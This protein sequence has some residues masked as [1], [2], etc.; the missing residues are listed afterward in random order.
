VVDLV[1]LSNPLVISESRRI[2]AP[3]TAIFAVLKDPTRHHQFDGST[4]VRDSDAPPIEAVGD[5]FIMRM[6]NDE[7]GDYEMRSEVIA[8]VP[9]HEIA[10]APQRHDVVEESWNHRWGWRLT[11]DGDATD[12][13]A[14]FDCTRV[15]A[16]GQRILRGGEWSR[17]I[18]RRSLENLENLFVS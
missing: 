10:W 12:V 9:D 16:D 1:D 3:A 14:Y 6:H 7:F 17:P 11:P 15:P 8:Y 18:L 5:R 13:V 4:M 2:D